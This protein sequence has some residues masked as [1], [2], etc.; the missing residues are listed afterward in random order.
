MF[1]SIR[2]GVRRVRR[3]LLGRLTG[4]ARETGA[5]TAE[6]RLVTL[7]TATIAFLVLKLGEGL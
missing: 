2:N 6:Y 7:V 1:G 4:F 3:A 5:A